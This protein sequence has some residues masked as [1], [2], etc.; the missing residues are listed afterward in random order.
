MTSDNFRAALDHVGLTQRQ[1]A[2]LL[3]QLGDP[4]SDRQRK[5]QRWATGEQDVPGAIAALLGL[6]VL[7]HRDNEFVVV[8][9]QGTLADAPVLPLSRAWVPDG[10]PE[11]TGEAVVLEDRRGRR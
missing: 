5:V 10:E 11:E 6:L 2:K 1:F 4:G 9:I 7:L 8:E 3:S